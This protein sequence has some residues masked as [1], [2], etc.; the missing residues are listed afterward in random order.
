FERQLLLSILL[1]GLPAIV[2]A[3]LLLW[4]GHYSLDHKAEGTFLVLFFWVVLSF[5]AR[6]LVINSLR[7]LSNV[8]LALKEEDFSFRALCG[9]HSDAIGELA[10]EI[11]DLSRSLATERASSIETAS[12]LRKVMAETGTA[13]FAFSPDNRLRIL[14]PAG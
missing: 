10:L 14:N 2:L 4:C 8:V 9:V 3:L 12:L 6:D 1:P 5:S 11:N 7:V 13:V